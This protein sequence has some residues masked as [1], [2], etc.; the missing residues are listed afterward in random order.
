MLDVS[1]SCSMQQSPCS[2]E[3]GFELLFDFVG[4]REAARLRFGEEHLAVECHVEHAPTARHKCY[5]S[6]Q[7]ISIIVQDAL[8]QP[9]G[10]IQVPSRGAIGDA[11]ARILIRGHSLCLLSPFVPCRA[12]L[13]PGSALCREQTGSGCLYREATT[14]RAPSGRLRVVVPRHGH[15]RRDGICYRSV[16]TPWA[17]FA[18]S[19]CDRDEER[20][21]ALLG[22]TGSVLTSSDDCTRVPVIS[23]AASRHSERSEESLGKPSAI[24][25]QASGP[26]GTLIGVPTR[27]A[28]AWGPIA[29]G[30]GSGLA[31]KPHPCAAAC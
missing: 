31:C 10:S 29:W 6:R 2:V 30:P 4:I 17:A 13:R 23:N 14:A 5:S 22:M 16:A 1:A 25:R 28:T 20:F 11:H 8:R 3:Q 12:V 7:V 26:H 15:G 19:S 24:S 21:L 27:S 9:G 18:A